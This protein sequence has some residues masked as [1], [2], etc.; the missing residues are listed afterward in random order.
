MLGSAVGRVKAKT[1]TCRVAI[2]FRTTRTC[3]LPDF[4]VDRQW[5]VCGVRVDD[6]SGRRVDTVEA[7]CGACLGVRVSRCSCGVRL[8]RDLIRF[9]PRGAHSGGFVSEMFPWR[10]KW[11]LQNRYR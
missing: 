1:T 11:R 6:L 10:T 4:V 3:V 2:G 9:V 5:S 7:V 8:G